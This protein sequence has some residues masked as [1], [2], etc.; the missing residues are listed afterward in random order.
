MTMLSKKLQCPYPWFGGKRRVAAE[1]WRRFGDV[2]N[3][4]EPFFGGGAVL[5]GRPHAA[6]TETINDKDCYVANFWRA[7]QADP[8]AV[9]AHCDWPVNEADLQAR[10]GWLVRQELFRERIKTDPDYFDVKIAGWWVWGISQ[11]IGG[12]WC[13]RPEWAGRGN[14]AR[15]PRGIHTDRYQQRPNLGSQNGVHRKRVNLKAGGSGVHAKLPTMKRALGA[16]VL[17]S[18]FFLPAQRLPDLGGSRGAV[19]KGVFRPAIQLPQL[20]GGTGRGVL[21]KGVTQNLLEYMAALQDRLRR[22]RVCC[23]DFER[24]LGPSPTTCIGVTGVF[25][26]PPYS[27]EAER[28]PRVY[29]QDDLE[30]AHRAAAWA[31]AQGRN[32][33]LRIAFCGYA[34]EHEFPADWECLAWKANGGYGNQTRAGKG[35]ANA[36]RERIW[37]SPYCRKPGRDLFGQPC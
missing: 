35:R 18:E 28:D 1:V 4:V 9:A 27:A 8:E 17:R 26:D 37:F 24:V 11:W 10:H 22:V 32:P 12:G 29:A 34:G 7:V 23:G 30:V 5:L 13:A 2:P 25:L 31:L 20:E 33:K 15:A 6:R 36:D 3:Y 16:G 19:G 14:S 21:T